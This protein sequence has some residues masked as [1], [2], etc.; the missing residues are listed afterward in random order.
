MQVRENTKRPRGRATQDSHAVADRQTVFAPSSAHRGAADPRTTVAGVPTPVGPL[1][2][3]LAVLPGLADV[4]AAELAELGLRPVAARGGLQVDLPPG[5][6]SDLLG[7]LRTA[8]QLLIDGGRTTVSSLGDLD[9]LAAQLAAA[10][11]GGGPPRWVLRATAQTTAA[12][13]R[14]QRAIDDRPDPPPTD[15][16]RPS[17]VVHLTLRRDGAQIALDPAGFALHQR[18]YRL[19]P[20]PAPLRETLAAAALRWAGHQPTMTVWDPCCGAG[21]FAIEALLAGQRLALRDWAWAPRAAA[22]T[23][24]VVGRAL[25]GDLDPD[26]VARTR[27][28]ADRAGVAGLV[29]AEVRELA[30][31]P[32]DPAIDLVACNLPWGERIGT[33]ADARRLVQRWAAAVARTAPDRPAVVVVAEPQLADDTGLRDRRVLA[34][35]NGG[36]AVWLVAGRIPRGRP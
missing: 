7:R 24:S 21:T 18:G 6:L 35:R 30:A 32:P 27:S 20:G 14:L 5:S 23:G 19:D 36:K 17:V 10:G 15:P 26:Q 9:R 4:T 11:W 33:R 29:R 22:S 3:W 12:T 28:N 16:Q 1:S 13:A 34:T 8:E 25:C 31:W 2:A